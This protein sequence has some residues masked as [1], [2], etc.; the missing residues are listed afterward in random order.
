[1]PG[2][3]GVA[4]FGM[5]EGGRE[6]SESSV[7]QGSFGAGSGR[8]YRAEAEVFKGNWTQPVLAL[9]AACVGSGAVLSRFSSVRTPVRP[10]LA[11]WKLT[12]LLVLVAVVWH[13]NPG[14][15]RWFCRPGK[16][17]PCYQLSP[18]AVT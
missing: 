14:A 6:G 2:M 9:V 1:M 7:A 10:S 4:F 17:R 11:A 15:G 8:G 3:A 12:A 16:R 5:M 18:R 13:R